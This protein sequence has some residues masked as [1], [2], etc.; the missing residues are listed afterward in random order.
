LSFYI[1]SYILPLLEQQVCGWLQKQRRMMFNVRSCTHSL[2][3]FLC[4]HT[5]MHV[6]THHACSI[7]TLKRKLA[8][9]KEKRQRQAQLEE[10][11]QEAEKEGGAEA[12]PSNPAEHMEAIRIMTQEDFEHI[13]CV[14]VAGE[15]LY[16]LFYWCLL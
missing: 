6:H 5:H 15:R 1:T 3:H 14:G 12:Q 10:E 4:T 9:A 8:F 11:R 7:S 16:V 13:K 2:K